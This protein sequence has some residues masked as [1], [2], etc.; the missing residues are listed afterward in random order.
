MRTGFQ[1]TFDAHDPARLA[2]FW[3]QVLGYLR[4]PPPPGF[5]MWADSAEQIGCRPSSGTPSRA[6]RE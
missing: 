2:D 5:D 4:Q 6:Q 1:A 3:A